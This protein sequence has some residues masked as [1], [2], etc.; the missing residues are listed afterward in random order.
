MTRSNKREFKKLSK[1]RIENNPDGSQDTFEELIKWEFIW[2]FNQIPIEFGREIG[3][4]KGYE[5]GLEMAR[6]KHK[7]FRAWINQNYKITA[8][9]NEIGK[10]KQSVS[11]HIK[12]L[13]PYIIKFL[14][15]TIKD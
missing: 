7:V 10:S 8:A 2:N 6:L 1:G 12:K 13:M 4:E 5:R 9:A 15:S 3:K 11:E 14:K